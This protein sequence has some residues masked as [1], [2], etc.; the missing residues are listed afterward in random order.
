MHHWLY[1][2]SGLLGVALIIALGNVGVSSSLSLGADHT[3]EIGS[4]EIGS[5]STDAYANCRFGVGEV[6]NPIESYNVLPLN[7]GWY[8]DWGSASSASAPAEM[9]YAHMVRVSNAGLRP[10]PSQ[11]QDSVLANPG[12]VWLIGNEPDR[13]DMQD[14]VLPEIYAERYHQAY[15]LI[16]DL[17]P[18]ARVAAGG[19]V[20][21]TPIRMQYLDMVLQAYRAKHGKAL[22]TDA[23]HVHSF[24]LREASCEAYPDSCWGAEIPPGVEV[25]HGELYTLDDFDNLDIFRAR[26]RAFRKWMRDRGYRDTALWV[27]EYGTLLPYYEDP[28]YDS[29]G[30]PFDEARARDFLYGTFDFMLTASDPEIGYPADN[31]RLVQRWIWYSLDDLDYGGA[32][33]DPYNEMSFQL[34]RDWAAY[35]S[36]LAPA[37]DLIAVD[38]IQESVPFSPD[39]SVDVMLRA[40]VSNGGNIPLTEPVVVRFLDAQDNQIGDP[41]TISDLPMAGCG[42]VTDVSVIWSDVEPGS[43]RVTF[44]VDFADAIS[45]RRED[46]NSVSSSVLVAT[47][48]AYSPLISRH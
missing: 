26:L 45:E 41:I 44:Q 34:G 48:R 9:E 43:H 19:I 13:I 15:T 7:L 35:T 21:P 25:D 32:L 30:D 3:A 33:F 17:D 18:T 20:Q 28:Y 10:S 47:S 11:L 27:T 1:V 12:A 46:N 38:V 2:V 29:N 42:H 24:I 6:R 4:G 40:R 5:R 36:S 31:D 8:V 22:E 14:D 39:E 23:W 37:V 16:K